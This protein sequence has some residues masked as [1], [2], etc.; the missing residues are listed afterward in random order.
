VK[1]RDFITLLG[2]AVAWPFAAR[3]QQAPVPMIGYLDQ[4][5]SE[6]APDLVVAFREG[7]RD[8][9]RLGN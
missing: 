8:R 5:P 1:R 2:G 6:D 3:T 7:L 9:C 4:G